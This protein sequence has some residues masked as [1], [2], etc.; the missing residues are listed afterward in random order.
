MIMKGYKHRKAFIATQGPMKS[1]V[2]DFWRMMWEH[3]SRV[4]VML[5]DLTEDGKVPKITIILLLCP[6]LL[7]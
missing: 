7:S 1:T 4:L 2:N 5:C 3:K 6:C